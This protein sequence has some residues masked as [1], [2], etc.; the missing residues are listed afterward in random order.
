M[1]HKWVNLRDK[2]H[3]VYKDLDSFSLHR[4]VFDEIERLNKIFFETFL[5][6]NRHSPQHRLQSSAN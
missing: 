4:I 6:F 2:M 3:A 5:S 1:K